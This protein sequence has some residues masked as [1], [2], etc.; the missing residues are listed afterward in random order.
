MT[1]LNLRESCVFSKL[2]FISI[3]IN[4][5]FCKSLARWF[6]TA[7]TRNFTELCLFNS[8]L[9]DSASKGYNSDRLHFPERLLDSHTTLKHQDGDSKKEARSQNFSRALVNLTMTSSR[10]YVH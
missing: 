8:G 1:C 9:V 3:I 2:L 4:L 6:V 5:H 7:C 10:T